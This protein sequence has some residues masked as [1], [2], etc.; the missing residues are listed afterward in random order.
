[1]GGVMEDVGNYPA[2]VYWTAWKDTG[3]AKGKSAGAL[4]NTENDEESVGITSDG[5]CMF[6]YFDNMDY[7]GDIGV[8]ML[9]SKNWQKPLMMSDKINTKSIESGGSMSNDGNTFF[10]ASERKE[11]SGGSDIWVSKREGEGEWSVAQNL[12]N[13][14][15]TKYDEVSPFLAMDGKTL[16]FCSKGHNSIGGFDIFK[17][18]YD[19]ATG[20]WG[21]PENVGYPLNTADDELS[22]CIS[23]NGHHAY[24]SAVR[25]EGLGDK[26]IYRVT[27]NE[28]TVYPFTS[29]ISGN[30]IA[31]SGPKSELRGVT[32]MNKSDKKVVAVYKPY[33]VSNHYVLAARP[34]NYILRVEGYGF[35]PI[36]EE[37]TIAESD[38]PADV[39]K[40][41]TVTVSK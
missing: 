28:P 36:E 24:I 32:L 41:F 19:S 9:K 6:L 11:G 20:K 8:S 14:I 39:V 2:D 22:F 35:K 26:D 7:F 38:S 5:Q 3:W 10:F 12:G 23:G 37:I 33:F 16:F 34:G 1:M 17:T 21:K 25:P 31:S 13:L 4:V 27:F 40:D 15:N 18:V 29:L 30:V